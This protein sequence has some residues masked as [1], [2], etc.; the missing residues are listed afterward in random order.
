MPDDSK[1]SALIERLLPSRLVEATS[2]LTSFERAAVVLARL[3]NETPALKR[4]GM[5]L[6]NVVTAAWAR[7]V[8]ASRV[9]IEGMDWLV[10]EEPERGVMVVSNHRSFFDMYSLMLCMNMRGVQW[11]KRMFFPVRANFF[12]ENPVGVAIN[13]LVSGG[14]M[15]P[16]IFRDSSKAEFNKNTLGRVASLLAQPGTLVG[17]HPE[18]T[19]GKGPDP[20]EFLPAQPG[21][22]RVALH[23]RPILVP[24]FINGL[25]NRVT[26]AVT[27]TYRR[28]ARREHPI[29]L[30]MGKPLDYSALTVKKPRLA[31]YKRCADQMMRAIGE[32]GQRER[33]LRQACARGEIADEDPGWLI[34]RPRAPRPGE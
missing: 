23:A 33:V 30:V 26:A 22:G 31:L 7:L 32:L 25:P 13:Y 27:D 24:F 15:Y 11:V 4:A 5:G 19:R 8:I 6:T 34:N 21:V 12:Y 9:Y 2:A 16:P 3:T 14:A 18:G 1:G 20:Y 28:D 10:R 29:I 17:L